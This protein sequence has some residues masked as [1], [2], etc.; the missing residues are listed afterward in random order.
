MKTLSNASYPSLVAALDHYLEPWPAARDLA[1]PASPSPGRSKPAGSTSPI[2]RSGIPISRASARPMRSRCLT[3]INDFEALAE[4]VPLLEDHELSCRLDQRRLRTT[5]AR[6]Q[7]SVRAPGWASESRSGR[8]LAGWRCRAKEG[9]WNWR[10][11]DPLG[12][13]A[14]RSGAQEPAG[15]YRRK[16][17]CPVPASSDCICRCARCRAAGASRSRPPP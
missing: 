1:A 11:P 8:P 15:A 17:V 4:S 6:K 13:A 7:S 16:G 2:G 3:V 14:H 5:T 10:H 12:N 9:T